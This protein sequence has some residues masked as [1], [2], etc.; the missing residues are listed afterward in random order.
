[1]YEFDSRPGYHNLNKGLA[2]W[3][4]PYSFVALLIDILLCI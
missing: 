2:D 4:T 1:M 3:L